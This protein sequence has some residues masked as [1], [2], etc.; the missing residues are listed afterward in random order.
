MEAV[1]TDYGF[2]SI[3]PPLAA[4]VLALITKHVVISLFLGVWLGATFIYSGNPFTGFLHIID[5]FIQPALANSDHAAIIIFS[6]LL[7]GMVGVISKNGGTMGIVSLVTGWA[8]TPRSGQ[9]AAWLLGII[10]F[11]D[12]YANTLIVGH[13]MRPV[14]DRLK[15]SRE[16][17]AFIVDSTSA[18]VAGLTISTWIGYEIGL[19]ADALQH[20]AYSG[21]AFSVFFLSIPYRFYPIL[22]IVFVALIALTRR[23]FGPML[24]AE[25]RAYE[26]GKLA[27]DGSQPAEDL[28]ELAMV[29]PDEG[30]KCRWLNG[31]IPILVVIA[32]TLIGLYTSGRAE[33]ALKGVKTNSLKDIIG[34]SNPFISLLWAS[35]AG[36]IAAILLAVSQKILTFTK[37]MDA[38]FIGMKSML[39]A[40]IILI[41]AWSIGRVTEE[42]GT[43]VYLTS[44]LKGSL[45]PSW[46]PLLTFVLAAVTSFAT[47]TSWGTMA[48]MIPL[49]L[50]LTWSLAVSAGLDDGHTQQIFLASTSAVLGGSIWGDHCSPISDTTV[51]SSMASACNH[52]DHVRTQM[53]YAIAVGTISVLLGYI[54][55]GLG[56]P[57]LLSLIAGALALVFF[58]RIFGKKDYKNPIN[59]LT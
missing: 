44:L 6:M 43:A 23:D 25:K 4:I 40:M 8:R 12:D 32:V 29:L 56:I 49:V 15:I 24:K 34:A 28:T 41:L 11:F 46:L 20:T 16:K 45:S 37:A 31:I 42:M 17:L 22:A 51:M 58:L 39:L 3:L 13:T 35:L 21:D 1:D 14:A 27:A 30:T 2:L 47:G 38:W 50:P 10:I 5:R 26:T 57:P 36:C 18:P 52:V 59:S 7:G 19:I 55:T 53:P 33:L 54:P 9:I 48:I